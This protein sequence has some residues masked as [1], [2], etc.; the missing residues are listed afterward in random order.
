MTM[1]QKAERAVGD[2]AGGVN[3]VIKQCVKFMTQARISRAMQ[4]LEAPAVCEGT[5]QVADELA[6]GGV[7]A[8][9]KFSMGGRGV[10]L[11]DR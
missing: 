3:K 5:T 1:K 9:E 10:I 2:M 6:P 4:R 7:C 11:C 8:V